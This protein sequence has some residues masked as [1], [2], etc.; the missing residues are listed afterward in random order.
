MWKK[1]I[2][3]VLNPKK[4][5]KDEEELRKKSLNK[6]YSKKQFQGRLLVVKIEVSVKR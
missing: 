5:E 1:F 4:E 3:L 6:N 2:V